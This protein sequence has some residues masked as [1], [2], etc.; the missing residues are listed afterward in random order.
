MNQKRNISLKTQ[1]Y[2]PKENITYDTKPKNKMICNLQFP[3]IVVKKNHE[4][5]HFTKKKLE[6]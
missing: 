4:S 5:L 3:T 1:P 2:D 6:L